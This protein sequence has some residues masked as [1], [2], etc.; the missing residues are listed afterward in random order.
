[1]LGAIQRCVGTDKA[2][3]EGEAVTAACLAGTEDKQRGGGST[4]CL[5]TSPCAAPRPRGKSPVQG[6]KAAGWRWRN[7]L[8][9]ESIRGDDRGLATA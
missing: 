2:S 5:P 3:S 6:E 9:R 1:M 8:Q 7:K 4:Q